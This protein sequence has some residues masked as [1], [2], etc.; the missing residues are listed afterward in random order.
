MAGAGSSTNMSTDLRGSKEENRKKG[1]RGLSRLLPMLQW[2]LPPPSPLSS[3]P[4]DWASAVDGTQF[5][6]T[7]EGLRRIPFTERGAEEMVHPLSSRPLRCHLCGCERS[8]VGQRLLEVA[9]LARSIHLVH[10]LEEPQKAAPLATEA[11]ECTG[12]KGSAFSHGG[13]GTTQGQQGSASP[14]RRW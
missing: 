7:L 8:P 3:L 4:R 9:R 2:L 6:Q 11:A 14:S 12:R 1:R 5:H 10:D 13:S